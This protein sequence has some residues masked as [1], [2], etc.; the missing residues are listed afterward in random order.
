MHTD[1]APGPATAA[2]GW[3]DL[4]RPRDRLP[5]V[6]ALTPRYLARHGLRAVLVDLDNTLVGWNRDDPTAEVRAWLH[7]LRQRGVPVGVVSNNGRGRVAR[8]C[9]AFGLDAVAGA[10]KP[11]TRGLRRALAQLG[12]G[13]AETA[14]VGDR[15]LT[16][17]LAGNRAGLYTI[18]VPA[19]D[20]RE[21][22]ATR[23]L[24]SWEE[25]YLGRPPN[26]SQHL[27]ANGGQE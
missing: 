5:G 21:L 17:V 12:T 10:G 4:L 7:R 23:V 3:R 25:R 27:F 13:P 1:A 6:V 8:F 18:L 9:D 19:L 15:L 24:R 2:P 14:L 16:D 22:W 11:G 26:S 20:P